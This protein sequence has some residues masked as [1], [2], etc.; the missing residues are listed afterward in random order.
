[1]NLVSQALAAVAGVTFARGTVSR[2]EAVVP[3]V[4][5]RESKPQRGHLTG[6]SPIDIEES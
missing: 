2:A 1:V 3:T 5:R 6:T 4:H